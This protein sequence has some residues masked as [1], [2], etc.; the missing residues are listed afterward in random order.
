[1]RSVTKEKDK[2]LDISKGHNADTGKRNRFIKRK[3]FLLKTNA[4][5]LQYCQ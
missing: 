5:R 1:M 4:L 3:A 2:E